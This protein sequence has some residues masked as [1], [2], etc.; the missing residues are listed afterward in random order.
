MTRKILAGEYNQFSSRLRAVSLF[1]F[2]IMSTGSASFVLHHPPR[3]CSF[4]CLARRT[5]K[6]ER[7]L[8]VYLS[9][10]LA[11]TNISLVLQNQNVLNGEE[12]EKMG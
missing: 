8:V 11:A 2:I 4:L 3:A 6:K 5:K 7:L 12:R 1:V 9:S 10:L